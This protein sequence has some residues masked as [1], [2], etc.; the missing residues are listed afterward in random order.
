[1][2]HSQMR[3][4]ILDTETTGICRKS[5]DPSNNHGIIEIACVELINREP[6]G[7]HFHTYVNPFPIEIDDKATKIHGIKQDFLEDKPS[8]D[9]IADEL[10][11]FIGDSPI[12]I[13]NAPFDISF[14]NREFSKLNKSKQ[15][16][17]NFR[18]TDTLEIARSIFPYERNDLNTLARKFC[19]NI[20]RE[21]HGAL[22]DCEILAHVYKALTVETSSPA[23]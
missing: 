20:N 4:I 9:S 16:Q 2:K 19:V 11:E 10:L 22:T 17:R 21:K 13:H 6:S 3:E 5:K 7:N 18:Y 8:F 15:P 1:M 12:I 23:Y 14:L